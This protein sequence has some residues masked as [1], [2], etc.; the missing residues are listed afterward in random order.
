M[1]NPVNIVNIDAWDVRVYIELMKYGED[2]DDL[3]EKGLEA[4]WKLSPCESQIRKSFRKLKSL[5][6]DRDRLRDNL[7]S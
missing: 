7:K 1:K 6:A 5:E 2:M 4:I 3:R